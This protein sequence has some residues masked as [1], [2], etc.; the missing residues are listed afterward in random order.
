M[1]KLSQLPRN[2]I[3]SAMQYAREQVAADG[4]SSEDARVLMMLQ[5]DPSE[6]SRQ[7]IAFQSSLNRLTN[8]L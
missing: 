7:L 1:L 5:D 4:L 3:E 2:N 8:R 6:L